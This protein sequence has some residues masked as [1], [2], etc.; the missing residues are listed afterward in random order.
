MPKKIPMRTCIGCGACREKRQLI[1][2][3]RTEEGQIL[4]DPGGRQNGRGAYLCPDP[5]CLD[6]AF[7]RK[8]LARAFKMQVPAE[9]LTLIREQLRDLCKPPE[10]EASG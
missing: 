5:A 1:R 9:E 7:Q 8:S 3:V 2:I 4:T 10:Q 6:K